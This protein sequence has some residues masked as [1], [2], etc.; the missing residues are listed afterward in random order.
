[1]FST[2]LASKSLQKLVCN[3]AFL[4]PPLSSLGDSEKRLVHRQHTSHIFDLKASRGRRSF[5][6]IASPAVLKVSSSFFFFFCAEFGFNDGS[7]E[8]QGS[9]EFSG[10]V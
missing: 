2:Y 4:P 3:S 7:T 8:V 9:L 10:G 1:M 5:H 6:M